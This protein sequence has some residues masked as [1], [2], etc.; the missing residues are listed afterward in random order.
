M[1]SFIMIVIVIV[2]VDIV[3]AEGYIHIICFI[4]FVWSSVQSFSAS[5]VLCAGNPWGTGGFLPKWIDN[6]KR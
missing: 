3:V 6:T 1:I 5:L 2:V 4:V